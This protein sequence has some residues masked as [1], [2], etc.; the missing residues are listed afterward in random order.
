MTLD[1]QYNT[2]MH[3]QSKSHEKK[4][5]HM[6]L[7]LIVKNC[8]F[9][10]LTLKLTF[11]PWRWLWII[12]IMQEMDCPVKITWKAGIILVPG[13]I[14][15]KIIFDLEISGGH[16]VFALKKFR[17]R[18]PKWHPADSCSGHPIVSESI[19][20]RCPYRETRFRQNLLDYMW[21]TLWPI[22]CLYLGICA[23]NNVWAFHKCCVNNRLLIMFLNLMLL[24]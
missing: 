18:V 1:H 3:F 24:A 20:K 16:F 6:F 15:W 7:A 17:L 19:I 10:Y 12:K 13:F 5:L 11:W 22:I 23:S 2:V 21:T 4:V 8:I 14:C 9:A